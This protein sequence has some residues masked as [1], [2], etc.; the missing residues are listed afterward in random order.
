MSASVAALLVAFELAALGSRQRW[1][2]RD[3]TGLDDRCGG[4]SLEPGEA[5]TDLDE[6]DSEYV[7]F[8]L[9]AVA[10]DGEFGVAGLDPAHPLSATPRR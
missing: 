5:F 7:A 10:F 4:C 1:L 3:R 6:L 9:E 8:G 2:R